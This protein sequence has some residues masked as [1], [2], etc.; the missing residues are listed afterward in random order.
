MHRLQ[1]WTWS[2]LHLSQISCTTGPHKGEP[3]TY[4]HSTP[5]HKTLTCVET[6]IITGLQ[7]V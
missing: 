4:K 6:R 5:M 1:L 3:N 7:V 2:K